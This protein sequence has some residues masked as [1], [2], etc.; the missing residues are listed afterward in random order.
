MNNVDTHVAGPRDAHER[1]QVR[2][3]H[4]NQSPGVVNDVAN[5]ANV[6]LEQAER[7]RICQHQSGDIAVRAQLPQV[8]EISQTFRR[9]FDRFDGESRQVG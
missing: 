7:V 2:A 6:F 9:R 5:L 1:V 8:I 3:V 4:V